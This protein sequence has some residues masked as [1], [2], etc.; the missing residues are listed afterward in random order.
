MYNSTKEIVKFIISDFFK[1][2]EPVVGYVLLII[3]G[4]YLLISLIYTRKKIYLI[5][6]FI[7]VVEYCA[8]ILLYYFKPGYRHIYIVLLL[9]WYLILNENKS[10]KILIVSFLSQVHNPV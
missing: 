5:M 7:L 6:M 1:S 4:I 2:D 3:T 10:N 9:I 8:I